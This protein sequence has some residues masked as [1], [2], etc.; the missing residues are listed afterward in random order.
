[1]LNISYS[2]PLQFGHYS[3]DNQT[4]FSK[5]AAME[6]SLRLNSPVKFHFNDEIFSKVDWTNEPTESL[7]DLYQTRARQIRDQYDYIVLFYS[8]GA[9]SHNMLEAFITGGIHIDEIA[10]FHSYDADSDKMSVANREIY[11]TAIPYIQSLKTLGRLSENIPHRLIDLSDI[12]NRF[13]NEINWLDFRYFVNST[14]SINNPARAF[15]RH[16]IKDWKKII[17]SG[18]RLCLVW[19]HDKPRISHADGK[20]CLQFMDVV[21]NCISVINQSEPQAG[22]YDELFYSTPHLPKLIIKQ[23][24][25]IIKFLK[26][27]P[28]DHPFITETVTGLG[29]MIRHISDGTWSAYWLTQDGQSY[30]IYPWFNPKLYYEPKPKN[31]IVSE[32]DRWFIKDSKISKNYK[33]SIDGLITEF[34]NIWLNSNPTIGTMSSQNFR[35]QRYWLE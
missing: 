35:T 4:V 19:G 6:M 28:V 18:K 10:S 23:A 20:F 8:G 14:V 21:D 5:V 26:N 7:S 3:V 2:N 25:T 9:D 27:T 34:G 29:H 12:I 16:Y 24:H 22:Y 30:L 15:L 17:D 13:N 1:L 33:T 11:E 32:R 31:I